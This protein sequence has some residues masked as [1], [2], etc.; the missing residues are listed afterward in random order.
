MTQLDQVALLTVGT[1]YCTQLMQ[2]LLAVMAEYHTEP[3]FK[4]K[5]RKSELY[6]I[7]KDSKSCLC[8]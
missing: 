3:Y 5:G 2:Y 8:I 4:T 7:S 6:Y 1:E